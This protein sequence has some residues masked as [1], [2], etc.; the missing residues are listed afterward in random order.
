MENKKKSISETKDLGCASYLYAL[1][2]DIDKV[3][4]DK[5]LS[6]FNFQDNKEQT[7]ADAIKDYY[8]GGTV[9]ANAYWSA[10]KYLKT[11]IYEGASL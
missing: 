9:K 2:F 7:V 11:I 3:S 8:R 4:K 5:G 10:T 1:G 6:I